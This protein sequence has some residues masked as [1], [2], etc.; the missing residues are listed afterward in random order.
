MVD[1]RREFERAASDFY[2]FYEDLITPDARTDAKKEYGRAIPYFNTFEW[3]LNTGLNNC[4]NF[5][6]NFKNDDYMQP[7][8]LFVH[9]LSGDEKKSVAAKFKK[10]RDTARPAEEYAERIKEM[11][12]KDGLTYIGK[13]PKAL[14]DS[15]PVALFLKQ[16]ANELP[17]FHWF[18]MRRRLTPMFGARVGW[19]HKMG[20]NPVVDCGKR[21]V[22]SYAREKDYTCFAGYFAVNKDKLKLPAGSRR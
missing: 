22:F 21:S 9:S 14:K 11:A 1:I 20:R 3:A 12:E 13:E 6:L 15:F 18:A 7:G 8:D 4:Y 19:F 5:A 16:R 17:D 10:L 2:E